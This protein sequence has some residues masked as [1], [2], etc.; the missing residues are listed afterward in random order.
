MYIVGLTGKI[1]SGKTTFGSYL[2]TYAGRSAHWESW[3]LI[4]EIANGLRAQDLPSPSFEDLEAVN[5]WLAPL[6]DLVK[7]ATTRLVPFDE[8]QLTTE[9]IAAAPENYSKLQ[10]Y[11]TQMQAQPELQ[12]GDITEETKETFRSLLQ[13]LGG[14]LIVLDDE[15]IW[16]DELLRRIKAK[17]GELDLATLGGV[18]FPGEAERIRNANGVV[19]RLER[20]SIEARDAYDLTE[21]EGAMIP[22]DT[23]VVNDGTLE[24]LQLVA[25][26]LWQDLAAGQLSANYLAK[27]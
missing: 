14:Y 13:W 18:R 6:P 9:K 20:P 19:V 27:H 15:G 24:D 23:T 26:T 3:Q 16:Y 8:I 11:L 10:E 5:Q 25:Q 12:H 2:A 22:S 21:R 1:D 17:E 7:T 4:A